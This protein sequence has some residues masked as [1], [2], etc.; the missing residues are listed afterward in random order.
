MCPACKKNIGYSYLSRKFWIAVTDHFNGS[1]FNTECP[2]CTHSI[3]I[4]VTSIP[5]FGVIPDLQPAG[6][7]TK[8]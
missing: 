6:A 5:E 1:Y 3:S 7:K 4:E 2:Y 8:L